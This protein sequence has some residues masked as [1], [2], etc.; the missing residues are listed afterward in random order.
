LLRA[1]NVRTVAGVQMPATAGSGALSPTGH[2]HGDGTEA[3][4]IA[5]AHGSNAVLDVTNNG[6]LSG[7]MDNNNGVQ[8]CLLHMRQ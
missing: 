3:G 5:S 6:M 2:L 4:G 8:V 7:S 1:L